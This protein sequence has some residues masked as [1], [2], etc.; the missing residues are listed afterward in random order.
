MNANLILVISIGIVSYMCFTNRDLFNKL[1][2]S[3]YVILREKQWY[4]FLT[5]AWV[6]GDFMHL[7]VN[8]FVLYSFG[9]FLELVF[10]SW[11]GNGILQYLLLFVGSVIIAH[12]PTYL[13]E[14]DSYN[15]SSVGASGG[16][17]GVLFASILIQPL[18]PLY[19][20]A[21]IPIP[22]IMFGVL[23]MFYTHRMAAKSSD[24]INHEAHMFGA[25][26]GMLILV[27]LRPTVIPAFISQ[28]M[29]LVG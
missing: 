26:G 23:Y 27:V 15:Y 11:F 18:Q 12:I 14:K 20:F 6:H 9:N 29:S 13:K 5:S 10:S 24:N 25:L 21:I 22:G 2:F 4:R 8:L 28:L 7:F 19:L 3:P 17:S 16:V 1:L